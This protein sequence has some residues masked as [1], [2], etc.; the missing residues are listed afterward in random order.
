M[1]ISFQI[2]TVL[3][4]MAQLIICK[5][6]WKFPRGIQKICLKIK[7][8]YVHLHVQL[9][10]KSIVLGHVLTIY[11]MHFEKCSMNFYNFFSMEFIGILHTFYIHCY[12]NICIIFCGLSQKILKLKFS[13]NL[14]LY[15]RSREQNDVTLL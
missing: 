1:K 15:N 13:K 7:L 10:A 12:N 3:F 5:C 8:K 6:E 2:W 14:H 4:L 11:F 9:L